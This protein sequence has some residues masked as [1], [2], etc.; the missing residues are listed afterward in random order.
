MTGTVTRQKAKKGTETISYMIQQYLKARSLAESLPPTLG[1][2]LDE[3]TI[4]AFVEGRLEETES[5]PVISHL[6]ACTSCRRTTAQL[7]R[8][9]SEFNPEDD[10]TAPDESPNRMRLLLE[11]AA[12]RVTQ[13]VETE[14]FGDSV[15]AYQI[16]KEPGQDSEVTAQTTPAELE[17]TGPITEIKREGDEGTDP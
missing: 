16:P 5:S 4:C 15:I 14:Y 12:A 3:D 1:A 9:E 7:V 2:H 13:S 6:V 11:R 10:L 17:P 8:L